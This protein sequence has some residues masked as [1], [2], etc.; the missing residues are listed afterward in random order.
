MSLK[1][2]QKNM[3]DTIYAGGTLMNV[4]SVLGFSHQEEESVYKIIQRVIQNIK[5]LLNLL[6][7]I[8]PIIT[9]HTKIYR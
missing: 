4:I 5:L 3:R 9:Y 8:Y 1:L 2:F 7:V 6:K